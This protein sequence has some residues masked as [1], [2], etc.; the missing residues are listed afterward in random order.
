MFNVYFA[1]VGIP[2]IKRYNQ[3]HGKLT[4]FTETP[5]VPV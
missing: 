2:S 4:S 1:K 3:I 5:I